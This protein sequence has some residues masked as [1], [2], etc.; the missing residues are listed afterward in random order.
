MLFKMLF[1]ILA[2]II[3][4]IVITY[5]CSDYFLF[6][7]VFFFVI[8]IGLAFIFPYIYAEKFKNKT[9][10]ILLDNILM[11]FGNINFKLN[12]DLSENELNKTD[13]FGQYT[14]I[15]TD[16]YFYGIKDKINFYIIETFLSK[17]ISEWRSTK[18]YCDV[19]KGV[20]IKFT[21]VKKTNTKTIIISKGDKKV[22]NKI[23]YNFLHDIFAINILFIIVFLIE[24]NLTSIKHFL[25][26]MPISAFVIII[27]SFITTILLILKKILN[28]KN[29][30]E[31]SGFH[32]IKL[33]DIEFEKKYRAYSDSEIESRYMLTP[34]FLSNLDDIQTAF[35]VKNLKCS[36]F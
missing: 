18:S 36:F 3:V 29:Q 32:E 6:I 10:Y 19:F 12:P 15:E 22:R 13:L 21:N 20:I 27:I 7:S 2:C 34:L 26:I 25:K 17:F 5:I 14:D 31:P 28:E 8:C 9:K 11:I 24:E 33:E 35:G 16:D 1:S 30:Y 4:F 23:I